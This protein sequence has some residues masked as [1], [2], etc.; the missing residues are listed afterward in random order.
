MNAINTILDAKHEYEVAKDRGTGV[1]VA[2]ERYMRVL[3][4]NA[5]ALLNLVGMIDLLQNENA[6]LHEQLEEKS[7]KKP[8][9]VEKAKR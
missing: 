2:K 1:K 3:F 7:P 6:A 4:N 8:E 9:K 5:E